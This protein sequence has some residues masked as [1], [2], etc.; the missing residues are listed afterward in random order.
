[1][2][3]FLRP[4]ALIFPA[5]RCLVELNSPAGIL[6]FA[7][8]ADDCHM[9]TFYSFPRALLPAMVSYFQ[10]GGSEG[11]APNIVD[12]DATYAELTLY[13]DVVGE[14][15]WVVDIRHNRDCPLDLVKCLNTIY[16]LE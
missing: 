16:D 11:G 14:D 4:L 7:L 15:G 3:W 8:E 13:G 12:Q 5:S 1:L 2:P 6:A 9:I 10:A